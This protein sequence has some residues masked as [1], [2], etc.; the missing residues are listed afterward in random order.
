MTT[1]WTQFRYETYS[2]IRVVQSTSPSP[3]VV[4]PSLSLFCLIPNYLPDLLCWPCSLHYLVTPRL[5]HLITYTPFSYDL[6]PPSTPTTRSGIKLYNYYYYRSVTTILVRLM[7]STTHP[8]PHR[9]HWRWFLYVLLNLL[10]IIRGSVA[11]LC[12]S[13]H[14]PPCLPLNIKLCYALIPF[15]CGRSCSLP[16]TLSLYRTH[17]I[18]SLRTHNSSTVRSQSPNPNESFGDLWG[19]RDSSTQPHSVSIIVIIISIIL[20]IN[21]AWHTLLSSYDQRKDLLPNSVHFA[22]SYTVYK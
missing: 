7:D 17:W 8:H 21:Q 13:P 20:A 5:I 9:F 10:I 6:T 3:V 14:H 19:H 1:G 16:F 4:Y 18:P 15:N 2:T 12:P 11:F 22:H